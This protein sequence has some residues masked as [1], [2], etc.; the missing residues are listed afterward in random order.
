MGILCWVDAGVD[1]GVDI[2]NTTDKA[3][4]GDT[5]IP[6]VDIVSGKIG[7]KHCAAPRANGIAPS[8]SFGTYERTMNPLTNAFQINTIMANVFAVSNH[9]KVP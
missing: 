7:W 4:R 9:W 5:P 1:L 8:T 3:Q 2:S 6:A